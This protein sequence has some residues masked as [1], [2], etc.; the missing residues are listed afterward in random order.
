L[1]EWKDR[2]VVVLGLARQGK[3]IC[4]FLAKKGAH[5]VASDLRPAM[6][7][8]AVKEELA[9]WSIEYVL[10]EHPMNLLEN[11][12]V[13][14][15]S[16]GV[17]LSLPLLQEAR[18]LGIQLSND[19]Q[20][21]LELCPAPVIGITG[22]AGKSTTTALVGKIA[23]LEAKESG[24]N[25]WVGG[26]IGRPLLWDVEHIH[27]HDWVVLELS[28]FQLELIETSPH[29]AGL[30]NLS[31]NHLDRHKTMEAYIAAKRRIFMNQSQ[32]DIAILSKDDPVTWDL[33]HDL[34][35]QIVAFGFNPDG[36]EDGTYVK[37]GWI[38]YR[39]D[40]VERPICPV[41]AI[42]LRGE[43]NVQN[44]LAAS[45]IALSA[46]FPKEVVEAGIRTFVGLAHRLELVKE[47]HGVAWYNDSIATSP[48]RSIAAMRSF[49]E[50]LI[51]LAGG[52]DK[53]LA[54]E[55]FCKVVSER[56]DHLILFGEAAEK[57]ATAMK[58]VKAERPYSIDTC[59]GLEDAV[60]K[61]ADI[62][63][64]GDIVLLAPGGTS[65]DEFVDFEAR[66]EKFKGW[67]EA[68]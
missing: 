37:D 33:R 52:R 23:E 68:L 18:N 1:Q 26:N 44:V 16:G 46:G 67:V 49:D 21:F 10:G 63:E 12:T 11:T 2:K 15:V 9:E 30:L 4:Q 31:P 17:P 28:S 50:P 47:V 19:S 14:F 61:A 29:I 39:K 64:V 41:D 40:N 57:I 20:L 27:P 56:V 13:V 53:D 42:P 8:E 36:L 58:N 51:L 22:S 43:H 38:Y 34:Q 6:R 24:T 5:V 45:A 62:A 60:Q 25:A 35:S 55:E 59:K 32:G 66:G 54:W 3:A 7:L 48:D 65:F